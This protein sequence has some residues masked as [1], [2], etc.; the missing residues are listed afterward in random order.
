MNN[1]LRLL[2]LLAL[3]AGCVAPTL[4]GA[5]GMHDTKP[6]ADNPDADIGEKSLLTPEQLA[7][8]DATLASAGVIFGPDV[9]DFAAE[10]HDELVG[11]NTGLAAPVTDLLAEVEA[12]PMVA[13]PAPQATADARPP[14]RGIK[15]HL[16]DDPVA[17]HDEIVQT[18]SITALVADDSAATTSDEPSAGDSSSAGTAQRI[19]RADGLFYCADH[20]L[21]DNKDCPYKTS[22]FSHLEYHMSTHTGKK[23]FTCATCAKTF[24]HK[25]NLNAHKRT[26]T[27]EKPFICSTCRQ[28]FARKDNLREHM[29]THTGEKLFTCPICPEKRFA[30]K[31]SLTEHMRK[32]TSKTPYL[33]PSC[34]AKFATRRTLAGHKKTN[35]P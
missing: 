9:I 26:H 4:A 22:D 7:A 29:R 24:V 33:C 1:L 31:N 11:D 23:L 5:A 27:G 14:R 13:M 20:H 16:A 12:E 8:F 15:R 28:G 35:H 32:H 3:A 18:D 25:G 17:V 34:P 19:R 2:T 6:F 30:Q 21:P 10:M